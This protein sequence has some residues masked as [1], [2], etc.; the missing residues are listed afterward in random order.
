VSVCGIVHELSCDGDRG[1]GCAKR[2]GELNPYWARYCGSGAWKF[3]DPGIGRKRLLK[4]SAHCKW[5]EAVLGYQGHM[6][7]RLRELDFILHH[8][9]RRRDASLQGTQYPVD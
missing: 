9:H 6:T 1:R 8:Y 3:E 7:N 5:R 2:G 4:T